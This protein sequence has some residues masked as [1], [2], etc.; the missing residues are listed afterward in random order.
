MRAFL[1]AVGFLLVAASPAAAASARV[2]VTT[3][4]GAEKLH[5]RGSVAFAPGG[6]DALTI[7]VDPS[8]RYQS[9]DGFGASI[10]DSSGRV[11]FGLSKPQR[12]AAM[13][14]LFADNRL[15]FLRQPIGASDFV[16][17]PH[18]TAHTLPGG[19][20]ATFVWKAPLD[21]GYRLLDPPTGPEEPVDDDAVTAWTGS[22]FDLDLGHAQRVRR[23]VIDAGT[24]AP[25]GAATLSIGG[26]QWPAEGSGQLTTFDIPATQARHLRIA[27]SAPATVADV[28]TYR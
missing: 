10:T 24:A 21:D 11:L 25:P 9:M 13:R 8:R 1:L 5:D 2:W 20:L 19:A 17:G 6:S 12:D 16:A 26:R 3:P 18:Y 28:R 7:S 27:F 4:D 15:S 23:V 22:A 14:S